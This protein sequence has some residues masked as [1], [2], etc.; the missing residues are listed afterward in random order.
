[1]TILWST[2]PLIAHFLIA[3]FLIAHFLVGPAA[4]SR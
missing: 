4:E 2:I 3:H 1:L